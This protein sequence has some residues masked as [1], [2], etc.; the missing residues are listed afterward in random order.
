M[1]TAEQTLERTLEDLAERTRDGAFA[2]QLSRG[3][4]SR[5]WRG[6]DG[7]E[8]SVSWR[9][10]EDL[11]NAL[12]ARVDAD[13]LELAQTGGEGELTDDVR[14]ELGTRGWTSEALD[15]E[16]HQPGHVTSPEDPPPP[17]QGERFAPGEPREAWER[18]HEEAEA[19]GRLFPGRP[20][21]SGAKKGRDPERRAEG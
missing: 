15:T 19:Q 20:G 3:L 8:V 2:T 13:A 11:V 9:R 6:P 10:A 7:A 18:A 16:E 21:E 17:D 1:T 12:R 4:A 14:D 5:R